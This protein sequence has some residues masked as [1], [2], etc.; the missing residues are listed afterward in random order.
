M[1]YLGERSLKKKVLQVLH[2]HFALLM[3]VFMADGRLT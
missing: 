2:F 3:K 1:I